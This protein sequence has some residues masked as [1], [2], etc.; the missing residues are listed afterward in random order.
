MKALS[1]VAALVVEANAR[2]CSAAEIR[3]ARAHHRRP[4]L[5]AGS[6]LNTSTRSSRFVI[7]VVILFCVSHTAFSLLLQVDVETVAADTVEPDI[8]DV[9]SDPVASESE[10]QHDSGAP[11]SATSLAARFDNSA[12]NGG[13]RHAQRAVALE[14]PAPV[15]PSSAI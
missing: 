9:S 11:E 6:L 14:L 8:E 15:E 3:A 7:A 2:A 1:T 10:E 4:Q 5:L 13:S 12:S